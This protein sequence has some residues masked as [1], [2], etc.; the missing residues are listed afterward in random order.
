MAS[1]GT[2]TAT[3][4]EVE[5][6]DGKVNFLLWKMRVMSLLMK[7]GTH[8][9]LQGIS[10]KPSDMDKD[11][12]EDMD[13]KAR[14]TIVLCLSDEVLYN[15]MN[16]ESAAGLWSRLE[17]LYMSKSLSNKLY[18][19]K[20]LY[21]LRMKEGTPILQHLNL[22]NKIVSDL[23]ALE[24]KL[25]EGDKALLLLGS[26]PPSYDHLVTTIMYGKETLELEDVRV[27]L[28]NNEIMKKTDTTE[29]ASGLVT[30]KGRGRSR[31]RGPKGDKESSNLGNCYYCKKPGH[32]KRDCL[33]R[34]EALKKAGKRSDGASTS[35]KSEQAGVVEEDLCE[36]LTAQS[37]QGKLS[38]VWLLDSGA[39]YHMCPRRE[40]FS[41]YQPCDGGSVLMGNDA[42]CNVIGTGNIRM[43]MFDGQVRILS[44]VRHVPDMRKNLLSLGAL[45][46]QG[47]R[48]SGEGSHQGIKRLHDGSQGRAGRQPVSDE[49]KHYRW[50]CFGFNG[51]GRHYEAMA[52]AP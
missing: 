36:V 27:V 11:D 14:A 9:A 47:F 17:S 44:N 21:Y 30:K 10:K 33:K 41:T 26:L 45:E 29:E 51:E 34:E 8:R 38:D 1:K 15:V 22:F 49:G 23:L 12:W 50:R 5:K 52:Y 18:T 7:E 13:Y 2:T 40:W 28:I 20:Q 32:F 19:K 31:S 48:F 6:F 39:T 25:E 16:E 37:G 42:E 46:P 3:K 4:F 24:V 43:R 35:G